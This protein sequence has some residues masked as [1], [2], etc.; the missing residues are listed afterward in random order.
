MIQGMAPPVPRDGC[1]SGGPPERLI[2]YPTLLLSPSAPDPVGRER[3]RNLYTTPNRLLR[4][5]ILRKAPKYVRPA[6]V[7]CARCRAL[8]SAR[9]TPC[10]RRALG[11][12][13]ALAALAVQSGSCIL[14][15]ALGQPLYN[16]LAPFS[17]P[18]PRL[19]Y[20]CMYFIDAA[21]TR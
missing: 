6:F 13:T 7:W 21:L 3:A 1:R 10:A 18:K 20:A 11:A 12:S 16:I 14:P 5:T 15:T 8:R 17:L 2:P 9:V 19:L 4:T